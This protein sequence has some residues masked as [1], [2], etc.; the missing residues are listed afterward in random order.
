MS[1]AT[2]GIRCN[3]QDDRRCLS[4]YDSGKA[5]AREAGKL[6]LEGKDYRAP[7]RLRLKL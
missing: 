1:A 3:R 6:W 5:G 4:P 2:S 7:E